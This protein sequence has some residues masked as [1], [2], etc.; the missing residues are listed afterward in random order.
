MFLF[1]TVAAV[2]AVVV[3]LIAQGVNP[4]MFPH[5]GLSAALPGSSPTDLEMWGDLVVS[6][7]FGRLATNCHFGDLVISHHLTSFDHQAISC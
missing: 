6:N 3:G 5:P 2:V 1:V 7:D 4:P